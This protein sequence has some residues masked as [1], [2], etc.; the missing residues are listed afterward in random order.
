M[1]CYDVDRSI[2]SM[3]KVVNFKATNLVAIFV[4]NLG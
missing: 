3:H 2:K 1:R 4:A